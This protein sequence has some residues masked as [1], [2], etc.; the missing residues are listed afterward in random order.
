MSQ[1]W[2][3]FSHLT[4]PIVV[5]V[6]DEHS[7]LLLRRRRPRSKRNV[8]K[9]YETRVAAIEAVKRRPQLRLVELPL[10][11]SRRQEFVEMDKAC[12]T[13]NTGWDATVDYQLF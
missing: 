4:V 2:L 1:G 10:L 8:I 12:E 5:E 9:V 13:V 6:T 7:S 3:S 11:Y